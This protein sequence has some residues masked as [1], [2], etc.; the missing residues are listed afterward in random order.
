[1]LPPDVFE[2]VVSALAQALV[3]EYRERHATT[4]VERIQPSL[5][6]SPSAPP[7]TWLTVREAALRARCSEG[8]IRRE[9][10]AERLRV[11]KVGGRKSLRF[12][13]EW[14]DAWLEAGD[15]VRVSGRTK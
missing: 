9:V 5:P 8:T 15:A 1:M 11:V 3:R 4:G 7:P 12:R 10:R 14:I 13:A 6:P 2:A